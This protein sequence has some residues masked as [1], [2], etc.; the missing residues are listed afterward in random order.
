MN[1]V[2]KLI[3]KNKV[4]RGSAVDLFCDEIEL[5][6]GTVAKREYLGHPGAAAVLPFINRKN[7]VLVKQYRY[8]VNQITYEIPAGK[9]DKGETPLEC[10]TRELE[11]ETGYKAQKLGKLLSFYPTAAFSNEIIYIFAAF[12]LIDGKQNPDEDE[13]ISREI[14][15]FKEA[16][17]MVKTG[18]I[19]D[20]KTI[21]AL[22]YF[23]NILK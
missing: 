22:L 10:I 17:K 5:P 3:K 2:E 6:N 8:P 18:R 9:I 13:F 23:E 12:G 7:I 14:V 4:Y 15:S 1:I 20:S 19:K 16:V 21:I 11:E